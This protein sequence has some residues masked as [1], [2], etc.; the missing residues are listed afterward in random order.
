M[1]PFADEILNIKDQK[2]EQP[3]ISIDS[4]IA[5]NSFILTK[6]NISLIKYTL[7]SLKSKLYDIFLANIPITTIF[8]IF[9][10]IFNLVYE[11]SIVSMN[12]FFNGINENAIYLSVTNFT[13]SY[14]KDNEAKGITPIDDGKRIAFSNDDVAAVNNLEGVKEVILY[15][16]TV[17]DSFDSDNFTASFQ[18]KKDNYPN[19]LKDSAS[20]TSAPE[21]IS[22]NFASLTVPSLGIVYY[23]PKNILLTKG[24]FP[25]EETDQILLPDFLE[26]D[27]EINTNIELEV[28]NNEGQTA[29]K[30]YYIT[31]FYKTSY[32]EKIQSEYNIYLPYRQYSF[33]DLFA[34]EQEYLSYKNHYLSL[35]DNANINDTIYK[36]YSTYLEALG[37]NLGEML[38]ILEPD[39]SKKRLN[40][41]ISELF[42]NLKQISQ[43]EFKYGSYQ[44]AYINLVLKI[45]LLMSIIAI[46]LGIII[47]F[48]NK[49]YIKRR[50]K[51]MAILYSLGYSR[52]QVTKVIIYE[53]V[54][55]TLSNYIIALLLLYLVNNF[56]IIG[57]DFNLNFNGV[58]EIE[59]VFQI[60]LF[61]IVITLISVLF[62][63]AGIKKNKLKKYLC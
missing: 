17:I 48:I 14:I 35:N 23:N 4:D 30:E 28:I 42:P 15:N 20:Y 11:M 43:Y 26:N 58:F 53:Y 49:N 56:Y 55:T 39:S 29:K 12:N 40:K 33:L 31:G 59:R 13:D 1:L 62:S 27:Y 5:S 19:T 57:Q 34:T 44:K 51:E 54:I 24:A 18:I 38:I 41:E 7:I 52:F 6:K 46:I 8:I 22:F 25:K 16:G 45:V 63:V 3:N 32:D 61:I 10:C 2:I 60:L 50:N 9:L 36:D 21:K 47:V 37:T